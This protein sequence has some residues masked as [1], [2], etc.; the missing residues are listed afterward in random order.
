MKVLLRL[1]N[2]HFSKVIPQTCRFGTI[3]TI[4]NDRTPQYYRCG[5]NQY[6]AHS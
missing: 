5:N 6:V 3:L 4:I 2:P 1:R